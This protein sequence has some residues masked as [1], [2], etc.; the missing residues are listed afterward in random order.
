MKCSISNS[1]NP[2]EPFQVRVVTDTELLQQVLLHE[3]LDR[4]NWVSYTP[5][6]LPFQPHN[7]PSS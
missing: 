1:S 3:N 2:G 4:F 5:K 6:K 7:F